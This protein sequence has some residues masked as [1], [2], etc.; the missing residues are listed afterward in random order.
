MP[1]TRPLHACQIGSLRGFRIPNPAVVFH[2][3][4]CTGFAGSVAFARAPIKMGGYPNGRAPLSE[5]RFPNPA[6]HPFPGERPRLSG[7]L[8]PVPRSRLL[9]PGERPHIVFRAVNDFTNVSH[10]AK[11][12]LTSK[13]TL[14]KPFKTVSNP[15]KFR[16]TGRQN[17]AKRVQKRLAHLNISP[18]HPLWRYRQGRFCPSGGPKTPKKRV[19]R[20]VSGSAKRRLTCVGRRAGRRHT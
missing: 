14:S 5:S 12:R 15:F 4:L 13:G 19:R 3:S 6:F 1:L 9:P 8:L 11:T 2:S 18:R 20:D 7:S 10:F 16:S 17:Y